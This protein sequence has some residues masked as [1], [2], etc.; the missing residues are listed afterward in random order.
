MKLHNGACKHAFL[1]THG[2]FHTDKGVNTILGLINKFSE[3]WWAQ[4]NAWHK[5]DELQ[6]YSN[7]WILFPVY[8]F[9]VADLKAKILE[10]NREI[11]F[12]MF[13]KNLCQTSYRE[14]L[15]WRNVKDGWNLINITLTQCTNY[16]NWLEL[17]QSFQLYEKKILVYCKSNFW[18]TAMQSLYS[19]C[20]IESIDLKSIANAL[21]Y[22][23][24]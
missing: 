7:L 8:Y 4:A 21:Y 9:Q 16:P 24:S 2:S 15:P 17:S 20:I 23:H 11:C 19:T 22:M 18:F 10:V 6:R 3:S 12:S 5:L 1:H 14:T 13:L